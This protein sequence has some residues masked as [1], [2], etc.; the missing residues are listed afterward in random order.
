MEVDRLS[1]G[2]MIAAV[3]GVFLLISLFLSWIGSSGDVVPGAAGL[4]L[5]GWE[6]QNS[7]DI[8]LFIVALIA[9][10]PA[11]LEM[12]GGNSELPYVTTESKV[13]VSVIGLILTVYVFLD[14]PEG[15]SRK[16]GIWLALLAVIGVVYG[17]FRA[18]NEGAG[19][20]RRRV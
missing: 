2:Q 8:Y 18:M 3:S 12:M 10:V 14:F 16:F 9:I 17:Q 20:L 11:V 15:A 5:T 7:L 6:S 4:S 13:L 19:G 1:Q